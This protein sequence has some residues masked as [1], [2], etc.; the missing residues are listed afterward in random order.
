MSTIGYWINDGED[1]YVIDRKDIDECSDAE[2]LA[3]WRERLENKSDTITMQIEAFRMYAGETPSVDS[4]AWYR[5]ACQAKAATSIGLTRLQRR[6][7]A[8]GAIPNPRDAEIAKL[9]E[10]LAACR[11]RALAAEAA[12]EKLEYLSNAK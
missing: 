3:E 12:L 1:D 10:A 5:R 4:L 2:T 8:I 7:V 6:Q 11:L 9:N